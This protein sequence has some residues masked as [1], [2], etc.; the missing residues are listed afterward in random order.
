MLCVRDGLQ[1]RP[2]T[3]F[4][5]V[6]EVRIAVLINSRPNVLDEGFFDCRLRDSAPRSDAAS[7]ALRSAWGAELRPFLEGNC[8]MIAILP[9]LLRA[10]WPDMSNPIKIS[11]SRPD[12]ISGGL[13]VSHYLHTHSVFSIMPGNTKLACNKP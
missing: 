2:R 6:T 13:K 7:L 10:R 5:T 4:G 1:S 3:E 11:L 9:T 12:Q 8:R